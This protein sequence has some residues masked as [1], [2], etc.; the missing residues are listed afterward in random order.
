M[1]ALVWTSGPRGLGGGCG[2][3]QAAEGFVEAAELGEAEHMSCHVFAR[4][5]DLDCQQGRSG[6][7]LGHVHQERLD[8]GGRGAVGG[9]LLAGG[10]VRAV[11]V[12]AQVGPVAP[13]GVCLADV[14]CGVVYSGTRLVNPRS[15]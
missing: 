4:L 6:E 8:D 2:L 1:A 11:S 5:V 14:S 9:Y 15:R 13:P 10:A 12:G 3:D 7:W